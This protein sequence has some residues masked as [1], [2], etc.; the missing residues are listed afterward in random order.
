MS[1]QVI[2]E[3]AINTKA[4]LAAH[5][6]TCL[7]FNLADHSTE[8]HAAVDR[9]V[10]DYFEHVAS[11]PAD[12]VSIVS[13]MKALFSKLDEISHR[14]GSGLLETDERELI[15]TPV[16]DAASGAGLDLTRYPGGDPT[17][18]FRNF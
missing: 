1:G 16:L 7:E 11:L 13:A 10:E 14:F 2:R 18:P 3:I 5:W 15:V 17:L 9:A 4:R 6:A 12:Q 8:A